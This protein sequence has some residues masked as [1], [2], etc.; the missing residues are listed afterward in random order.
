MDNFNRLSPAEYER[1]AILAEE[2]GEAQQALGKIMRHGG[3]L[4]G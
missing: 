3:E 2:M 4:D 1:L